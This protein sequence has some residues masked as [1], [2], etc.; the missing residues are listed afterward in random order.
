MA[1]HK[2]SEKRARQ[3]IKKNARNRSTKNSVRT[4]EKKLRTAVASKDKNA[5]QELLKSFMSKIG[6]AAEK[7][8][9]KKTNAARKISRLSK[10]VQSAFNA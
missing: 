2:S 10:F 8:V 7:G 4:W 1:N 9:L 3:D 6:K 5:A